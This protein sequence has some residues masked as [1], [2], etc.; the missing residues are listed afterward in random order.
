MTYSNMQVAEAQ[1][2]RRL[3]SSFAGLLL[4]IRE[5]FAATRP[6]GTWG[7]SIVYHLLLL[8]MASYWLAS[9]RIP[10]DGMCHQ[11]GLASKTRRRHELIQWCL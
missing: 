7:G 4:F 2:H 1:T 3:A 9:W 8:K 5:G 10:Q 6:A 11:S